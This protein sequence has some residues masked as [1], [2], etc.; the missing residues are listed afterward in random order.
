MTAL[1]RYQPPGRLM[2]VD[3]S[4][5]HIVEAGV[6]SPTIVFESGMGGNVLDWTGV[7]AALPAA[8][9]LAY[10]RAGL[11]WSEVRAEP[12]TPSRIVDELEAVLRTGRQFSLVVDRG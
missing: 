8:R 7:M 5:V 3:G 11:G 10:D 9:Y 2:A 4:R 12:R 6:G 1:D